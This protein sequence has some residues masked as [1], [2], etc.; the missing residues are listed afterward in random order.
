MQRGADPQP[1]ACSLGPPETRHDD[2]G[3][4]LR[5]EAA[6]EGRA[7]FCGGFGMCCQVRRKTWKWWPAGS[8]GPGKAVR[9]CL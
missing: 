9:S 4:G 2:E 8:V 3:V 7:G 6:G 1:T 5:Q